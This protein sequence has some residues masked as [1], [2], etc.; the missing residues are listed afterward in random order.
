M[1]DKTN[2]KW[3]HNKTGNIYIFLHTQAIEYTNG[4]EYIDSEVYRGE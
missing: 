4:C 1:I 2:T 3:K